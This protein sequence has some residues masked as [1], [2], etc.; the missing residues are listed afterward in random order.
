MRWFPSLCFHPAPQDA[1]ESPSP[2]L[3]RVL[4]KADP[5]RKAA[6]TGS[7]PGPLQRNPFPFLDAQLGFATCPGLYSPTALGLPKFY[8]LAAQNLRYTGWC[9]RPPHEH[10]MSG[11]TKGHQGSSLGAHTGLK[12]RLDRVSAPTVQLLLWFVLV[13]GLTGSEEAGA[14]SHLAISDPLRVHFPH[15]SYCPEGPTGTK[16]ACCTPQKPGRLWGDLNC[17][18]KLFEIFQ[19]RWF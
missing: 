8:C 6:P 7:S 12:V 16:R 14:Q 19:L 15:H 18:E 9:P 1:P 11:G 2:F 5:L 10:R 4:P 13:P 3:H 17:S